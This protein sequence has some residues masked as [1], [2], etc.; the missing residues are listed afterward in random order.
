[1]KQHILGPKITEKSLT[2][3]SRGWYTFLVDSK[4]DKASIAS[5]I[6]KLYS[7]NVVEVRT[8]N[9]K[10]KIRRVGKKMQKIRKA[11]WKKALVKLKQGQ[12]ISA[13]DVTEEHT[14][15]K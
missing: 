8:I 1:M 15:K 7:V 12:S 11:D 3:A 9:T 13:F 10:G 5:Q 2:Q 4:I 6:A 14:E